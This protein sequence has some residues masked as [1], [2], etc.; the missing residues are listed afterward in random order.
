M[1]MDSLTGYIRFLGLTFAGLFAGF[2]N[3]VLVNLPING[4]QVGWSVTA[5]PA[6]WAD[7]R[8]RWQIAHAVRTVAAVLAFALL[9]AAA[10]VNAK[11]SFLHRHLLDRSQADHSAPA[12][13]LK[14]VLTQPEIRRDAVRTLRAAANGA[15]SLLA[16]AERLPSFDRRALVVWAKGDRVMPPEHGRR[17]AELLPRG[18][19]VE[20]DDSCTLIPLDQPTRLA[21]IIRGFIHTCDVS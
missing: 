6:G 18:Q 7:I 16:A 12:R 9:V 20:V 19:L 1:R 8:D 21:Q 15:G 5:P 14:P 17:L 11:Q 2:V 13:W 4:D 3:G 10:I